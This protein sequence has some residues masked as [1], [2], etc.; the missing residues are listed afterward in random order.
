MSVANP[1]FC[2]APPV[3]WPGLMR[4]LG[5]RFAGRASVCDADDVF[6]SENFSELKARGAF[7]AGVPS[8]LGGGG[9]SYAELCLMSSL[10]LGAVLM[11]MPI[12]LLN[13]KG[14]PYFRQDRD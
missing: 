12:V 4:E 10:L 8:T 9:A 11:A 13:L 6:V 5:P 7:A 1:D 14:R 3:D 2:S